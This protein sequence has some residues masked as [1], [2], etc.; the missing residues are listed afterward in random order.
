MFR[1]IPECS[2]MFHVPGFIDGRFQYM[3]TIIVICGKV[4][5]IQKVDLFKCFLT[6][7]SAIHVNFSPQAA[8][9]SHS[10]FSVSF[11]DVKI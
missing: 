3:V 5:S 4:T 9:S 10:Y 8:E 11:A 7:R 6:I 1:N 2:G